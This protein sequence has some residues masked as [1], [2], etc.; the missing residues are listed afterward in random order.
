MF[1]KT[2]TGPEALLLAPEPSSPRVRAV[3]RVDVLPRPAASIVALAWA[4]RL[5]SLFNMLNALLRYQPKFIYWLGKWVPFEITEG[6]R[7]RMF[8]MSVLLF[9]LASGLQ[10]GKR[11]AWQIT[12][13]G[14]MLAPIL[15]L[16]REAIWQ[17]AMVNLVLI[18]FLVA[19]R[20]YFVVE[21]DPRSIHS[22]LILC[23]ILALA[24][25]TFGTIRLHALH[26]HTLGE[27]SW[28][29]WRATQRTM[30]ASV[31]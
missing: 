9:V 23:P 4:V 17:P 19:Q 21:S 11:L 1:D 25:L 15:H 18:G 14:L 26:K 6:Y 7:V 27:H 13:A 24:L 30:P 3:P 31:H 5:V 12:I 8:L 16:G 2:L 10:R 20:R 29:A 28:P 22:A